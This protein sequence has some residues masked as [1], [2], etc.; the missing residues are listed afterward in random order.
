[1]KKYA[2][3]CTIIGCVLVAG[4]A[5]A[6]VFSSSLGGGVGY[7]GR[8]TRTVNGRTVE[9]PAQKRIVR[10]H[11]TILRFTPT[12]VD[13]DEKQRKQLMKIVD[14]VQKG[15]IHEIELVSICRDYPMN[16]YRL[17]GINLFF[18]G[19]APGVQPTHRYID[20]ASVLDSNN[21]TVE[22]WEYR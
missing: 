14:R 15:Q 16:Y 11:K 6:Q 10:S 19:Y 21:N 1:M 5:S 7:T 22:I 12:Q 13:L 9:V 3:M 4:I 2:L 8:T 17:S 20:P 18:Q